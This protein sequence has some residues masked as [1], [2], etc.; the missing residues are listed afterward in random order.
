[1]A[2]NDNLKEI[3]K[4]KGLTQGA[5]AD[6]A[7][8]ELA[9]ISRI[10]RGASVP[11]L[12]TIKKLAI[13]LNCS[14]DELIMD[15]V[16]DNPYYIKRI[17]AKINNLTPLRRF[18]LIDMINAYCNTYDVTE[19]VFLGGPVDERFINEVIEKDFAEQINKDD[20]E[21]LEVSS[22]I[23]DVKFDRKI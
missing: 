3:R 7:N 14:T 13:A 21:L 19:S 4:R 8:V 1:M 12:D 6:E 22:E 23:R 11:K 9:Q 20:I 17:I 5:L 18:V 2:I 10:E 16:T 15:N